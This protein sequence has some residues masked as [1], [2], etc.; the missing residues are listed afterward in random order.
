[1]FFTMK[2]SLSFALFKVLPSLL[3]S[4]SCIDRLGLVDDIY[5]SSVSAVFNP[6]HSL[7][8]YCLLF[9]LDSIAHDK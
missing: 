6:H 4:G 5:E 7:V 9:K 2:K 8:G 1:M 3:S